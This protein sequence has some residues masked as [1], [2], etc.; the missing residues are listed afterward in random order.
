MFIWQKKPLSFKLIEDSLTLMD[1]IPDIRARAYK[2]FANE[3]HKVFWANKDPLF[4][5]CVA[6]LNGKEAYFSGNVDKSVLKA[7]MYG[8]KIEGNNKTSNTNDTISTFW[9]PT[10]KAL[11]VKNL[12]ET[13]E[14]IKQLNSNSFVLAFFKDAFG[15]SYNEKA[16]V[17]K[18][19]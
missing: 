18:N 10:L 3:R 13:N 14:P 9:S 11:V 5:A 2:A 7:L 6:K 15:T 17:Y 4:L 1:P 19:V 12:K 16:L 8:L